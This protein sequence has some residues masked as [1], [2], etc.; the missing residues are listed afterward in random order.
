MIEGVF[1]KKIVKNS[2][3]R[4]FF[5]EVLKDDDSF[6]KEIRQT[7]YS[8]TKPG[9]IKAFHYHKLQ[10]DYF[11]VPRGNIVVVL[12]DLREESITYQ[13]TEV[14]RTGEDNPLLIYI[15]KGVAHGYKVLGNSQAGV[16][17]H[18]TKSYNPDD[19]HRIPYD[20]KEIGFDW[21]TAK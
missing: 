5:S 6:F 8:E 18:M 9:I 13:N 3:E 14:I 1:I 10:D 19:E 12:Y 11:F 21:E 7:S 17:Y 2:D 20:D 15:P 4:G 16:F